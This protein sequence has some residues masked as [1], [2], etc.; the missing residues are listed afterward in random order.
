M[1]PLKPSFFFCL[2][3]LGM[4]LGLTAC[5]LFFF[6]PG[7]GRYHFTLS[8][9]VRKINPLFLGAFGLFFVYDEDHRLGFFFFSSLPT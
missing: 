3:L 9:T 7:R 2:N 5:R 1:L 6:F 4:I 8:L